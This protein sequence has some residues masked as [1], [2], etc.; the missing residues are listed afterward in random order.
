MF[1]LLSFEIFSFFIGLTFY[2]WVVGIFLYNVHASPLSDVY[3]N[4]SSQYMACLF[5]FSVTLFLENFVQV[6][7]INFLILITLCDLKTRNIFFNVFLWK[8]ILMLCVSN[9]ID[10][11]LFLCMVRVKGWDS[12]FSPVWIFNYSR[13]FCWEDFIPLDY[14]VTSV[15]KSNNHIYVGLFLDPMHSI[16]T[17]FFLMPVSTDYYSLIFYLKIR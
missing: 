17:F 12:I 1:F 5:Y 11:K 7:C 15:G 4:I 9:M 13:V 3:F 10:F 8:F 16:D 2:Y 14:F 6:W